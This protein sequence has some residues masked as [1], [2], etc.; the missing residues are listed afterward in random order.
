MVL[1]RMKLLPVREFNTTII[2][3]SADI[4]LTARER[5]LALGAD[6]FLSKP[7]NHEELTELFSTFRVSI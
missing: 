4:Q 3:L 2:V 7:F 1:V 5:S 6:Y